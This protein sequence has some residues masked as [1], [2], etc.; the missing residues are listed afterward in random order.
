MIMTMGSWEVRC[1]DS[2]HMT[3]PPGR[4]GVRLY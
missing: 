3:L 2:A 1:I 4:R